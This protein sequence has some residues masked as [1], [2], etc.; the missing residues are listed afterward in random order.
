MRAFFGGALGG[1]RG[2]PAT[3]ASGGGG[4]ALP[5][6]S[7]PM[8]TAE[9]TSAAGQVTLNWLLPE[10][11]MDG[12]AVSTAPLTSLTIY[13][14]TTAD[15]AAPGQAGVTTISGI[16]ATDVSRVVSFAAATRYFAIS[17]TN[18]NGEGSLSPAVKGIST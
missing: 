3:V 1:P 9:G 14:N 8:F 5:A 16:T 13:H 12:T 15:G 18:A 7:S 4:A 10:T 6:P 2:R 11:L 17:A